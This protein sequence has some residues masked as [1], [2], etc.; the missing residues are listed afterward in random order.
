MSHR[1]RRGASVV[2]PDEVDFGEP[3]GVDHDRRQGPGDRQLEP[4]VVVVERVQDEAVHR[5]Y[6]VLA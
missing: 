3:R 6:F 1:D 2:D 4:G 5:D